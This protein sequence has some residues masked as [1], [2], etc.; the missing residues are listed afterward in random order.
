MRHFRKAA[1]CAVVGLSGYAL[2]GVGAAEAQQSVADF[3]AGKRVNVVIGY[4]PGGGYDQYARV[5]ARHMGEYIPGKPT[6]VPQAMPGAGSR[7]AA[8]WLYNVAP[9]DGTTIAMLGQ[10]TATD[11]ALKA[12][13]V[14]F[15]VRK[16]Y[17]IG[18]MVVVN[19][20]LAVWHTSGVKTIE[21]A[22]KKSLNIGG[23]GAAS[24][25]VIYPQVA[26]NLLGTRFKIIAGYPGGGD[27]NLAMER[28]ELDGRGSN[29]WASWKSTQA[30][31]LKEKKVHILFQ[32]GPKREPD[33][34]DVPLL[35]ELAKTPE[36]KK[37]FEVLS[38]DVSVGRP[39]LTTPGVPAERVA[40]LRKAFDDTIASKSFLADAEKLKMD[41]S[42]MSGVDLQKIV[43]E[44]VEMPDEI[45]ALVKSAIQIRDMEA[46]APEKGGVSPDGGN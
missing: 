36:Q 12:E 26:N 42:P 3:Y 10:N 41:I 28:G 16:F 6:L 8:N 45:I 44:T 17:W 29:S 33:L 7:K 35:T 20:T 40:A 18:N 4:G 24:P 37:V 30:D 11:Q 1:A 39:F 34:P 38:A 23:T 19:N 5:F 46:L 32:V 13:G 15:D 21:E 27:V 43:T 22:T 2:A 25:S 9:K 14:Q 31:W